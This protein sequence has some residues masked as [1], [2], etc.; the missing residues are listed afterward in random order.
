MKAEPLTHLGH[1]CRFGELPEPAEGHYSIYSSWTAFYERD[2]V[3][4]ALDW[5]DGDKPVPVIMP[6]NEKRPG[7]DW[8][9]GTNSSSLRVYGLPT[10]TDSR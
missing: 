4:L 2:P 7:G 10:S 3:D 5:A 9:A 6:A 1:S 8:E